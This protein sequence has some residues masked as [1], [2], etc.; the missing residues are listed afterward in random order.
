MAISISI[1]RAVSMSL[2]NKVGDSGAKWIEMIVREADGNKHE[3]AIF[4]DNPA[5]NIAMFLG[6]R[7]D[8]A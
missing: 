4:A 1:Y 5:K 6:C 7:E 8:D 2:V 3:F